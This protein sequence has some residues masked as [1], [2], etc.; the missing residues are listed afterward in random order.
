MLNKINFFEL[1]GADSAFPVGI[2]VCSK[3]VDSL[4]VKV[5]LD[6]VLLQSDIFTKS[7]KLPLL[8]DGITQF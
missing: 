3:K 1:M 2:N 6:M 7:L 5:K 8:H 4:S